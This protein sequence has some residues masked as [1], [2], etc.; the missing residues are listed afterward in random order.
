MAWY[1]NGD[2]QEGVIVVGAEGVSC[3]V[4]E[5]VSCVGVEGVPCVGVGWGVQQW[6][7]VA[8]CY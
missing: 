4:V 7:C 6:L 2:Y 3:A 1:Q 5:G 8:C